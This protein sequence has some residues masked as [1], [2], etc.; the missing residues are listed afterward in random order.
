[1]LP[2]LGP[3]L[4]RRR[5]C[6]HSL[7]TVIMWTAWAICIIC[8]PDVVNSFFQNIDHRILCWP[9]CWA[10]CWIL[11]DMDHM[12]ASFIFNVKVGWFDQLLQSKICVLTFTSLGIVILT[13]HHD[14]MVSMWFIQDLGNLLRQTLPYVLFVE[15]CLFYINQ[16]WDSSCHSP[17]CIPVNKSS[18]LDRLTINHGTI[19]IPCSYMQQDS[20]W[21]ELASWLSLIP[22]WLVPNYIFPRTSHFFS[23]S[24][25]SPFHF[26]KSW[27]HTNLS[28]VW[29]DVNRAER[30]ALHS[31]RHLLGHS[32]YADTS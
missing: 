31:M 24:S 18:T 29:L 16:T 12:E 28:Q 22:F 8:P 4:P 2:S 3:C 21:T 13:A 19:P 20:T 5:F 30:Q 17:W 9:C 10:R 27:L 14:L 25:F 11:Q 6:H 23:L 15:E 7:D 32:S 1:M 26:S